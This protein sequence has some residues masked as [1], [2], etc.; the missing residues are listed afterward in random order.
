MQ[1]FMRMQLLDFLSKLNVTLRSHDGEWYAATAPIYNHLGVDKPHANRRMRK[2]D[3]LSVN[4]KNKR[5]IRLEYIP[6]HLA[7]LYGHHALS[8]ETQQRIADL[9]N[10]WGIPVPQLQGVFDKRNT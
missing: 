7:N 10:H 8:D 1:S 2:Y 9:L 6:W 4:I 3:N 5:F